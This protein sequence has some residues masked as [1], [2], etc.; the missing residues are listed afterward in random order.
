GLPVVDVTAPRAPRTIGGV[1]TPGLAT[2]VALNWAFAFV[3]DGSGGLRIVSRQCE[4]GLGS[5]P[6][7]PP[8]PPPG[9]AAAPPPARARLAAPYPN[10]F[11]PR[12]T[13]PFTLAR[14]GTVRLAVFDAA[15]RLVATL[16]DAARPAG[17]G[18]VVWDG[19]DAAGRPVASGVYYVELR[20]EGAVGR[21]AL[22]LAR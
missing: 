5:D 20:S 9:G 6:P 1:D 17:E 10:P 12:V 8:P 22:L 19:R 11:N 14:A 7:D 16:L 2:A 13:V 3:A 4:A 21:R 15:G 18:R